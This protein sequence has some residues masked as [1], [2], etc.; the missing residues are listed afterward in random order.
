M[1][2]DD[3][4]PVGGIGETEAG[5]ERGFISPD[6][7]YRFNPELPEHAPAVR[8]L[9]ELLMENARERYQ[10]ILWDSRWQ[11]PAEMEETAM[12]W[13]QSRLEE[14][15]YPT[16]E[17]AEQIYHPPR[18]LKTSS[19]RTIDGTEN[20][21]VPSQAP[22]LVLADNPAWTLMEQNLEPEVRDRVFHE[23]SALA[24]RVM[25]ADGLD[26]GLPE[27]HESAI[28]KAG[29]FLTIALSARRADEGNRAVLALEEIPVAELFREG[30]A[31][32]EELQTRSSRLLTDGWPASHS[33]S[34]DLIDPPL[35]QHLAGLRIRRPQYYQAATPGDPGIPEQYRDFRS[36]VEIHE[37]SKALDLIVNVGTLLVDRMG[38]D[39]GRL[40]EENIDFPFGTPRF[41]TLLLTMMAWNS[42]RGEI[43]LE[44]L[45]ADVIADFLRNVASRRTA[46][47]EAPGRALDTLVASLATSA[48]LTAQEVE[49]ANGYGQAGLAL[50]ASE[51][52]QLDPGTPLNQR[53]ISCLLLEKRTEP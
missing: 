29:S 46:G 25:V 42:S 7:Y 51:C 2:Y 31:L 26:T 28:R 22:A 9:A 50:L 49:A 15:G 14:H 37:T 18:G 39:I 21:P 52:A 27:S 19:L 43:R 53:S 40:L 24:N 33:K 16:L 3:Q 47:Q 13:R 4:V 36:L 10:M 20:L 12:H 38:L 32:V 44:A 8:R 45:P 6:G 48:G 30:Y 35:R 1:E 41:S 23:L 34:L 11:L 17:E 5:D